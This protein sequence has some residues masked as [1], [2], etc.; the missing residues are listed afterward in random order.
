LNLI[1]II[2]AARLAR[3]PCADEGNSVSRRV[4]FHLK[5]ASRVICTWG[6]RPRLILFDQR[7]PI[8]SKEPTM[9]IFGV[10][11]EEH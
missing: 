8:A 11:V 5:G 1:F 9:V 7:P 4:T 2:Y 10:N 6:Y 3:L